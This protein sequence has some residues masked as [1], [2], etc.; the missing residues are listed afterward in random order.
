MV[1]SDL[2][3]T[4]VGII[5]NVISMG[6]FL[7]PVPTFVHIIKKKSVQNY[8]PEPYLATIL[9]CAMWVFYGLPFVH[10]DSTL[11]I[12]INGF[13]FVLQSIYI[14]IFFIYSPMTKW[15]SK[16]PYPQMKLSIDQHMKLLSVCYVSDSILVKRMSIFLAAEVAFYA[17]I[18]FCTLNFVHGTYTRTIVVG[19]VC[20]LLNIIMYYAPLTVVKMVIKTKSVRFMPFWLSLA[21]L[22]NGIVWLIY[23]LIKFDPWI[24]IPNG[25]GVVSGVFQLILYA[26]YY[27][28]TNWDKTASSDVEMGNKM[29]IFTADRRL[30]IHRSDDQLRL[31][32]DCHINFLPQLNNIDGV[33]S[34]NK[35]SLFA[36]T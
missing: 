6:L 35:D 30:A 33:F 28:S 34:S 18:A 5:G 14:A 12:T 21:S 23:G 1:S 31:A 36:M 11:V 24:A 22:C 26:I 16:P 20:V 13:G 3:R 27:K 32:I 7:S 29:T 17:V 9:N 4:I 19:A 15:V 8:K 10:P 25:V 2:L